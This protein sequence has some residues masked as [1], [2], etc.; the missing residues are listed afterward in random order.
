MGRIICICFLMISMFSC[1]GKEN[2]AVVPG[3]SEET[4]FEN[5]VDIAS[6]ETVEYS[7]DE[8]KITDDNIDIDSIFESEQ[9]DIEG[10]YIA[11][12]IEITRIQNYYSRSWIHKPINELKEE[13]AI[14]FEI[15][16]VAGNEY[17]LYYQFPSIGLLIFDE[18]QYHTFRTPLNEG[19]AFLKMDGEMGGAG[20]YLSLHYSIEQMFLEIKDY[21]LS[22]EY[23]E[24]EDPRPYGAILECVIKFKKA[25]S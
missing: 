18:R 12:E 17:L 3:M 1:S 2:N 22:I 20:T 21:A 11:D 9:I 6:V 5:S 25:N 14:Y 13:D 8:L 10:L 16:H 23:F 15:T 24:Y 4:R 19:A 7:E